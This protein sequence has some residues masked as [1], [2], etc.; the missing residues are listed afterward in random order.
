MVMTGYSR[1]DWHPIKKTRTILLKSLENLQAKILPKIALE[2]YQVSQHFLIPL[3]HLL[4][5]YD[6]GKFTV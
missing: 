6:F 2:F 3:P 5:V 1:N 4:P